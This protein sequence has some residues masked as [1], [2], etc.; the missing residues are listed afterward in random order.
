[1]SVT[2][3]TVD[4]RGQEEA[5]LG[6]TPGSGMAGEERP[7]VGLLAADPPPEAQPE[8][9]PWWSGGRLQPMMPSGPGPPGPSEVNLMRDEQPDW[10][11]RFYC[12][13]MM[14]YGW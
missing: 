10:K 3:V 7:P 11:W 8:R 13:R 2:V 9:G 6:S 14:D 12:G 4:V 1:M 5:E